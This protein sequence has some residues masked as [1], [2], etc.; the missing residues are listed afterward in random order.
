MGLL[1]K[2]NPKATCRSVLRCALVSA[3]L[4]T[5]L[6]A[7]VMFWNGWP[8]YPIAKLTFCAILMSLTGALCEW[9]IRC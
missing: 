6:Y 7:L 2:T 8:E 4:G 5:A 3:A 1:S 9:Q